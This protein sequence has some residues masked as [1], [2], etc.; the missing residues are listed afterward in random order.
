MEKIREK[1]KDERQKLWSDVENVVTTLFGEEDYRYPDEDPTRRGFS[2]D[3]TGT[4][5]ICANCKNYE[6]AEDSMHQIVHAK[7]EAFN[8][9]L[10]RSRIANCSRYDEKGRMSLNTMFD[11]ATLID[12]PKSKAGLI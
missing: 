7:C 3:H 5:G 12:L 4:V 6:Y 2:P 8:R 9:P 1:D 11:M 10:G